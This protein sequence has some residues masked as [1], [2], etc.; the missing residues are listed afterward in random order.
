MSA[1]DVDSRL[2]ESVYEFL[3]DTQDR[4]AIAQRE[5]CTEA[6]L[7][8]ETTKAREATARYPYP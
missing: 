8:S 1:V 5:L 2:N 4:G 3:L 7:G 6:F